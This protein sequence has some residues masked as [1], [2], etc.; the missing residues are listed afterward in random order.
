MNSGL[1]QLCCFIH[2]ARVYLNTAVL[3][4]FSVSYGI[5]DR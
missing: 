1:V 5:S 3:F 2:L 4:A